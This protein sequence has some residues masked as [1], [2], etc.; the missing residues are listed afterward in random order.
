MYAPIVLFVYNRPQHTLQTLEALARNPEAAASE[1]F[2][3]CDGPKAGADERALEKIT[4]TRAVIR[5]KQW[6]GQV[7][8]TEANENLGLANSVI[9]GVT[10]IVNEYGKVIV[11]EDDLLTSV[12][13]L[14]YMNTALDRYENEEKVMQVSGFQFPLRTITPAHQSYFLNYATSW[15]WATWKRAW[16]L[17]DP[18]ASGYE[19]LKT[20]PVLAGQFDLNNSYRYT[21]MLLS[22]VENKTIDSWAI[23][24]WWSVFINKGLAL[25]PDK[26]LVEN[27]GYGTEATHTTDTSS[28]VQTGFDEEYYI[29]RFPSKVN[30]DDEAYSKI[31]QHLSTQE[32]KQLMKNSLY[33]KVSNKIKSFFISSTSTKR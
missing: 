26:T 4:Q 17:F 28:F 3:F 21:D 25:F 23:R 13:F 10:T 6:C 22:Q 18:E 27:I 2:I 16:K 8:I 29:E 24:W 14:K 15:G 1:L 7:H 31:I 11:L 30:A 12:H 5:T 9:A 32:E 33:E 20:D 19:Q